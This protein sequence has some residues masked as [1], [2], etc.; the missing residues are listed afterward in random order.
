MTDAPLFDLRDA[1]LATFSPWVGQTFKFHLGP[2]A[3]FEAPLFSATALTGHARG[4]VPGG[5]DR[6]PFSL[7]FHLPVRVRLPQGLYR[8]EHPGLGFMEV[9]M[10]PV[11]MDAQELHLQAV[12]N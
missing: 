4:V 10:V 11:A 3:V 1:T 9:F 2:E 6:E 5:V 8:L 12:F 7:L